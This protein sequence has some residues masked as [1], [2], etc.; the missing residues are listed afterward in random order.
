MFIHNIYC[1]DSE[2]DENSNKPVLV[3]LHG[4]FMDGRMFT[5]QIH[6]LRHQYRIICPDFRGFGNTLWD[7]HPFSLCDLVD[8]VIRCLNELNIEQFYLAGMSMGGYV[9]QRLAIRYPNRV[10]GLILIATQHGIENFETI[11]QYHQLLDGWNNSLARSEIIDH[12]LEA[13]FDRNIHDKLYWK[14]IW[15]SLTYDQIFYPMHAMLTRESIETELR[16]LRMPCLILHGDADTGIP[17]SAAH[18]LKELLPQAI[19]HIIESGR[20][21]I[22]ITHYDEVNQAIEKFLILHNQ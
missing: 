16:L 17:V 19:L 10:K 12:L 3:M 13:F 6:A 15:S 9:A 1:Y 8:D 5:Q 11:E 22:N 21:A 14:Y 18:Q 2:F 7:K 4:F 20:H